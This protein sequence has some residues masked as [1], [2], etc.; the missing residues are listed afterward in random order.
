MVI[1]NI[2]KEKEYCDELFLILH[3]GREHTWY[4]EPEQVKLSK[5]FLENGADYIIGH[6]PHFV[7]GSILTGNKKTWFSLGNFIFPPYQKIDGSTYKWSKSHRSSLI[8]S[9]NHEN[10]KIS[11]NEFFCKIGEVD[12]IPRKMNKT[13]LGK[14]LLKIKKINN[15]LENQ[16]IYSRKYKNLYKMDLFFYYMVRLFSSSFLDLQKSIFWRYKNKNSK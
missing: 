15:L 16:H 5:E 3:W 7:Q 4:P 1:D 10:D 14:I 6:H 8:L 2:K 13:E 9:F 12:G 11:I